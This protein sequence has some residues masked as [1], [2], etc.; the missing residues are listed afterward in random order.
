MD[1]RTARS[2]D[3][4]RSVRMPGWF[5]AA[6]DRRFRHHDAF[7]VAHANQARA[8]CKAGIAR[9]RDERRAFEDLLRFA[10]TLGD[11]APAAV[12]EADG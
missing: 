12:H 6:V 9:F 7:V 10:K 4:R 2:S 11:A 1:G 3:R 5:P 8:R